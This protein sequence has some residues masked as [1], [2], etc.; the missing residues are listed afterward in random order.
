MTD[1]LNVYS[2]IIKTVYGFRQS[3]AKLWCK[4]PLMTIMKF[5]GI[6]LC[7]FI[8]RWGNISPSVYLAMACSLIVFWSIYRTFVKCDKQLE[9]L[10][11]VTKVMPN[12]QID[13][14]EEIVNVSNKYISLYY[15]I[16]TIN[17][18]T[19]ILC[20]MLALFCFGIVCCLAFRVFLI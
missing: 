14:L 11:T 17:G 16:K 12:Q 2:N 10:L 7:I 1:T 4:F 20:T 8:I 15:V 6:F 18:I 13:N 5:L 3:E 9:D 19:F